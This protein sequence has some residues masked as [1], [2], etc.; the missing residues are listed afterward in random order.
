[1]AISLTAL[2]KE[3]KVLEALKSFAEQ[4]KYQ[5]QVSFF[6]LTRLI[7][8]VHHRVCK[9]ITCWDVKR[10][11]ENMKLLRGCCMAY[12]TRRDKTVF[13]HD[14]ICPGQQAV[15][16]HNGNHLL[17][18]LDAILTAQPPVEEPL[19]RPA[20]RAQVRAHVCVI[21]DIL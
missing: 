17:A 19:N 16:K 4:P 21:V 5:Q 13:I 7:K 15:N 18:V 2:L 10:E 8:S 9:R 6:E 1:M 12:D 14:G 20:K 11:L 3:D